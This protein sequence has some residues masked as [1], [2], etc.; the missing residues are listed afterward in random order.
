[1]QKVEEEKVEEEES[2][3]REFWTGLM[4]DEATELEKEERRKY[5]EEAF[6]NRGR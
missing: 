2:H 6:A 1:M 5:E 3:D 4:G